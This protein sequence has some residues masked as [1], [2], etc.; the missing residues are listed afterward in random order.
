MPQETDPA[1]QIAPE[2]DDWEKDDAEESTIQASSN[3]QQ[4]S[5]VS[6]T[7]LRK[8]DGIVLDTTTISR[9]DSTISSESSPI[10][11][12]IR[13]MQ[14]NKEPLHTRV[15]KA[16][17]PVKSP[18]RSDTLWHDDEW[19]S[20]RAGDS[21]NRKLWEDAN[22]SGT[23]AM[24]TI[25]PH[26]PALPTSA[27]LRILRR[28]SPT[29]QGFSPASS[30]AST[31]AGSK[32]S[33]SS[34]SGSKGPKTLSE[35]EEEY[36]RARERI[37]GLEDEG[38]ST[39]E[40]GEQEGSTTAASSPNSLNK[41]LPAPDM[42]NL[43]KGSSSGTSSVTSSTSASSVGAPR[44]QL[45]QATTAQHNSRSTSANSNTRGGRGGKRNGRGEST[46]EPLRPPHEQHHQQLQH[47][48][49]IY[50]QQQQYQMQ[51]Q[52]SGYA[53]SGYV[54]PGS[55]Y[56]I[57]MPTMGM[58]SGSVYNP[59]AQPYP[60]STMQGSPGPAAT[61]VPRQL[62][63]PMMGPGVVRQPAGPDDGSLGF[64]D[65]R[66]RD[67]RYP[68][69]SGPQFN[70][71]STGSRP[72]A[73]YSYSNVGHSATYSTPLHANSSASS[74]GYPSTAYPQSQASGQYGRTPQQDGSAWPPLMNANGTSNNIPETVRKGPQSVWRP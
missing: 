41:S 45:S 15:E 23:A 26:V 32:T 18:V 59:Y 57:N 31:P 74:T 64:S 55:G 44:R 5:N 68:A 2:E 39:G 16:T 50:M 61:F 62:N 1:A 11:P 13:L 10:G 40:Q 9:E 54:G 30:G 42:P 60:S 43:P 72:N 53:Q 73:V 33:A 65:L 24:P 35:R 34:Q 63:P 25:P 56:G 14:R 27:A 8:T 17:E 69:G 29:S 70:E 28:P 3:A 51:M 48:Q 52:L 67:Q 6:R 49:Q 4:P 12:R 58:P 19:D 22:V 36:R 47:Q 37:F 66:I 21:S 46:F 7:L 20:N 71:R 38:N